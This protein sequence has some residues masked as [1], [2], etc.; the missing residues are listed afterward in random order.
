M[1]FFGRRK[2]CSEGCQKFAA[3]SK[4]R[5]KR[6]IA[7]KSK[8]SSKLRLKAIKMYV[9]G[10]VSTTIAQTLNKSVDTVNG[11][12]YHDKDLRSENFNPE[13]M[14]LLPV[15]LKLE[16][17]KTDLEWQRILSENAPDGEKESVTIVCGFY[18]S[19]NGIN[20]LA[21][22]VA[23]KLKEN[24]C[25]GTMYAFCGKKSDMVFTICFRNGTYNFAK[26]P[27][28]TGRYIWPDESIGRQIKIR[29]NEFDYLLNLSKKRGKRPFFLDKSQNI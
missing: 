20:K 29:K 6:K 17:A 9:Q 15:N 26:L 13:L 1:K 27:K 28:P 21:T 14:T 23:D 11:W 10:A 4:R 22:I 8:S 25:D 7:T 19:M 18:S 3:N 16:F 5:K 12:I 24:P 2:Y